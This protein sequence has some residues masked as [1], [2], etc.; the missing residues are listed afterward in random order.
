[1]QIIIE[2]MAALVLIGACWAVW[3]SELII[4]NERLSKH[5]DS[6]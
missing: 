5:R 2:L 3:Q 4:Q 6:Q 1:M